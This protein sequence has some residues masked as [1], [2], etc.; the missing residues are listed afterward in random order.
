MKLWQPTFRPPRKRISKAPL[1]QEKNE[2]IAPV[3]KEIA[4]VEPKAEPKADPSFDQ[5]VPRTA[6]VEDEAGSEKAFSPKGE[7]KKERLKKP[8]H[9]AEFEAQPT[10]RKYRVLTKRQRRRQSLSIAV[11]E[12]EEELLR[13]F[14][15][16]K[17]KSFSSWARETLF[18]AMGR[19]IPK[20][21]T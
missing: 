21:P 2:I 11:S 3:I 1:A 15:A 19:K 9:A 7:A 14:A 20:R 16:S 18:K 4:E 10:V 13:S 17:E 6:P 5:K 12:E 8:A